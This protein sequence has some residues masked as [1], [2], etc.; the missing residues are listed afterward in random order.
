M[1]FRSAQ[2]GQNSACEVERDVLC[3][4]HHV[5]DVVPEDPKVQHIPDEMHPAAVEEY[6]RDQCGVGGNGYV[7]LREVVLPEHEGRD[8]SVLKDEHVSCAEGKACLV[9]KDK[10]AGRDTSDR[11]HRRSL[12]W[13]VVV[14]RDQGAIIGRE[15]GDGR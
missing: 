2:G 4:P 7:H 10:D 13:V 1:L 11:D 8:C 5:F 15:Y 9:E 14:Q 6:A 3:M 12:G